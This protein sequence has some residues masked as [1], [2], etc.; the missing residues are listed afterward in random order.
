MNH[1]TAGA[2]ADEIAAERP[3]ATPVDPDGS[4]A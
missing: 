1:G 4:E 2:P 3:V